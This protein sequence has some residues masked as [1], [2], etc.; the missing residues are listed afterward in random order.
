MT[1]VE[2]A[3]V[4]AALVYMAA[5]APYFVVQMIRLANGAHVSAEA[6]FPL[7]FLGMALN[8]A[9]LVVTIRD[10]YLRP[11]VNP[12][13]KLTW[14]LLILVTGGIGWLVYLFKH[15]FTPR[16]ADSAS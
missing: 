1:R 7:H 10:L 2:R 11:F 4:I 12:N 5:Y 8:F 14:L 3:V 15:A 13:A 6:A 9:A 16:T